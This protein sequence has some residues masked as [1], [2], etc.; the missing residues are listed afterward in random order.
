[1]RPGSHMST[2][3]IFRVLK[4]LGFCCADDS[5]LLV[6][7]GSLL[8]VLLFEAESPFRFLDVVRTT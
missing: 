4:R 7:G 3:Q 1:M 5:Q 6:A 8:G 2:S